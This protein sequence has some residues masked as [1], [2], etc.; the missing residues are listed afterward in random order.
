M[1]TKVGLISVLFFIIPILLRITEITLDNL[2]G[3]GDGIIYSYAFVVIRKILGVISIFIG[4]Y[5]LTKYLYSKNYSYIYFIVIS[6]IIVLAAEKLS[7][8]G[9]R[10][11]NI[12]YR[13]FYLYDMT[14]KNE[15]LGQFGERKDKFQNIENNNDMIW[16]FGGS[17]MIESG[18]PDD[19]TISHKV[20]NQLNQ[21]FNV[22]VLNFGMH[23]F[24][25]DLELIK[26]IEK[27]KTV[28]KNQDM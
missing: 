24:T 14:E 9:V 7:V 26:F 20:Y 19:Q 28:E 12:E 25:Q 22:N 13:R 15:S 10:P 17:T 21:H 2:L 5:F 18:F 4:L 16:M 8:D 27:L 3:D 11:W 1:K 23:A 6:F